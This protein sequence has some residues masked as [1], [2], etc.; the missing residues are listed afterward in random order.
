MFGGK[1]SKL[2][3]KKLKDTAGESSNFR[4]C[5]G[6]RRSSVVRI[7]EDRISEESR[8]IKILTQLH[9]VTFCERYTHT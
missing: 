8:L 3:N 1:S 5:I 2:G 6:F 9:F 7:A 4:V